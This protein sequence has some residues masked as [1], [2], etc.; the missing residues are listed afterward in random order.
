[1]PLCG[2]C[3]NGSPNAVHSIF[4]SFDFEG[5]GTELETEIGIDMRLGMG[6]EKQ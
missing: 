1:M 6:M 5:M 2:L 3:W 4:D